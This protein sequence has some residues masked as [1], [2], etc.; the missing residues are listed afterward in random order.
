[1]QAIISNGKRTQLYSHKLEFNQLREFISHEFPRMKDVSIKF[2]DLKGNPII[3]EDQK[4]L[5]QLQKIYQGQNF[6]QID[7]QCEK[8]H[9]KYN[10]H[11]KKERK[12]F[13]NLTERRTFVLSKACGG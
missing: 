1:M 5:D 7:I 10:H 9:G 11:E 3:I 4:N 6:V 13:K 12:G 2:K 8:K